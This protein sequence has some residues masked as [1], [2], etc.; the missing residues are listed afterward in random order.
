VCS[1]GREGGTKVEEKVSGIGTDKEEQWV[2][3]I[4]ICHLHVNHYR[5]FQLYAVERI[6]NWGH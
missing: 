3:L 6:Q 5:L 4:V 1:L 2:K